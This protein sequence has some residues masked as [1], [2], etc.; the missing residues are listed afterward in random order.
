[1]PE[2]PAFAYQTLGGARLR[3]EDGERIYYSCKPGYIMVGTPERQCV[4]GQWSP[5]TFNCTGK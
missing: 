4:S 1:M 3:Y 2:I 5:V